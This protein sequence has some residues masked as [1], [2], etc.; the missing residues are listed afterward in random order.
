MIAG[1]WLEGV[2]DEAEM[3]EVLGIVA[4]GL[5]LVDSVSI[6]VGRIGTYKGKKLEFYI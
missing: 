1:A 3:L 2:V 6:E 4:E 5:L